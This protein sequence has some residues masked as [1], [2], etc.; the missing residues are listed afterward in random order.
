MGLDGFALNIGDA[1]QS[2][3]AT[4]VEYLFGAAAGTNFKLFISMDLSASG[5]ACAASSTSCNGPYDYYNI[6]K[7][8]L[9]NSAYYA[10][11]NGQPMISTFSASN[12]TN[13]DW[14]N[15]KQT[16]ANQMHF[17]PDF[18]AT[19]GYYQAADGWWSYWGNVVDGLFSWEA[20]WPAIGGLG[21]SYPGDVSPDLPVIAG[22]YS[23]SKSYMIALSTLQFKD[24]YGTNIY[25]AGDLNLPTR[26]QNILNMTNQPDFVQVI[27]WN[28]GPESHYIGNLWS[29][30]GSS[31][32]YCSQAAFPHN[33]WQP[34]IT[35]FI[36]AF[37]AGG[38]TASMAPPGGQAAGALWYKTILQSESCPGAAQPEGFSSGTDTLN[39]AV[40]LPSGSSGMQVRGTSG[41]NVLQTV[42]VY[43]G[44]SFGSFGGVQ[45][46][47]QFLELLDS[48][49]NVVMA[50]GQGGCVAA[51]CPDGLYNMNYQVLGLVQGG[52]GGSG[53]T[54]V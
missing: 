31:T 49:G 28:D 43:P 36:A 6:F 5:A 12:L 26:M 41:G 11:P 13:T 21:G 46:G 18:D 7:Q 22:A 9:G 15:W 34:L 14:T 8:Y 37:K 52:N 51:N 3:V 4:T 42:R 19:D 25:R 16:L 10:G 54:N 30:S 17:I 40:V 32:P 24:A 53:C 50:T 44:M 48:S 33:A 2:F 47:V 45:A 23:H 27:T 38:S 20:A 35:S 1:T 39:W 29:E